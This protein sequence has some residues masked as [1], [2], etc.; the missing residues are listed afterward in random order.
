MLITVTRSAGDDRA[1]VIFVDT[2]DGADSVG[3]QHD[4]GL[5]ILV[6]D[7][8]AFVGKAYDMLESGKMHEAKSVS[9]NVSL[10]DIDYTGR[11]IE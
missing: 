2:D 6:N 3:V 4:P 10:D 11:E 5:R 9:F 1:V 8:E 7:V